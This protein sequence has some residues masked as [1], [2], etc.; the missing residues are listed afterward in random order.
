[1]YFQSV[2][3]Q[4]V[5]HI[6]VN[7]RGLAYGDGIFT[8]AKVTNGQIEL[9]HQHINRLKTGCCLF[10]ILDVDFIVLENE[11]IECCKTYNLAVLKI[12]ITSGEGGR[13]YSRLGGS[14]PNII[15]KISEFP[16]KYL[17]WAQSGITLADASI[18]LGI[19][20]LFS[21][22]KHLNRLEQVLIRNELDQTSYDDLLVFNIFD[23][24]IETTCANIFWFENGDIFT[25]E[26]KDSGVAGIQR[27]EVLRKHPSTKIIKAKASD[28]IRAQS[29]FITNSIMEIVPIIN[30][31]GNKLNIDQVHQFKALIANI[32]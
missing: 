31:A 20:P 26:I 1:M 8:T 14:R 29:M 28:I 19:N 18:K 2:N 7:D 30:Y 11:L 12:I 9:I 22:V 27:A 21:G 5:N 3:G 13:G 15:I 16:T 4:Q 10:K 23:E 25:P 17:H 32:N 24:V 6:S